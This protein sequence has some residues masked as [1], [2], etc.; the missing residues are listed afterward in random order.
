MNMENHEILRKLNYI[1][2]LLLIAP[3]TR[4]I[5]AT[6]K[7]QIKGVQDSFT[8]RSLNFRQYE[9][10]GEI[11]SLW[12]FVIKKNTPT[13]S[14]FHPNSIQYTVMIEGKGKVQINHELR[15][16]RKYSP[17]D[18]KPWCVIG[19]ELHHEFFPLDSEMIVV[20]FQTCKRNELIEIKSKSGKKRMYKP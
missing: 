2:K 3:E 13:I 6:L 11:K 9:F 1:V 16:L 14:H 4:K 5:I 20:S 7:E 15:E 19:R 17:W 10:P 8:G 18:I 12:I